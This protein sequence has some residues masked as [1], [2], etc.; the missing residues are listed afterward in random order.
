[1]HR[2]SEIAAEFRL[3]L[4]AGVIKRDEIIRWADGLVAAGAYDDD[5]ANISMAFGTAD[6]ELGGLLAVVADTELQPLAGVKGMLARMHDALV[7]DPGRLQE[8]VRFLQGLSICHR[9]DVP[10]NLDFIFGIEDRYLF[11]EQGCW[12]SMEADAESGPWG[13]TLAMGFQHVLAMFGA[14]VVD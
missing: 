7:E 9:H 12:Q 2:Y 11:A 13:Q 6:Q 10:D 8:F 14:T 1:M 5:I 3:S 4:E